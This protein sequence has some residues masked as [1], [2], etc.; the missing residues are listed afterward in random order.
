MFVEYAL[1]IKTVTEKRK[2]KKDR[3]LTGA[4]KCIHCE[5]KDFCTEW[6]TQ[7]KR[8]TAY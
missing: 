7:I 8:D 2:K 4:G 1:T 3:L 6:E 5:A